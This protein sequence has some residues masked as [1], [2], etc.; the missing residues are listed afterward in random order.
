MNMWNAPE[1]VALVYKFTIYKDARS[2][3]EKKNIGRRIS[4]SDYF[5]IDNPKVF[6]IGQ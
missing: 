1:V 6:Q 3:K 2:Q 4:G 5:R